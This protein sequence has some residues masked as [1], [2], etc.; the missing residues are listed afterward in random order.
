MECF[1]NNIKMVYLYKNSKFMN[2]ISIRQILT[3]YD[4]NCLY[5]QEDQDF[6]ILEKKKH[7][8]GG[9]QAFYAFKTSYI[10]K[11]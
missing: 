1:C 2:R 11:S 9:M 3:L 4:L 5:I 7:H 10:F 8:L 6:G